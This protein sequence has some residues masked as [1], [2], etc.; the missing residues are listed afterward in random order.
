MSID[1]LGMVRE[2]VIEELERAVALAGRCKVGDSIVHVA[3]GLRPATGNERLAG[4]NTGCGEM[5]D[6]RS[7]GCFGSGDGDRTG[8]QLHLIEPDSGGVEGGKVA[9]QSGS[10]AGWRVRLQ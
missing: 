1:T 6:R 9:A 5:E 3:L 10:Q 2:L 8:R 4:G 7:I